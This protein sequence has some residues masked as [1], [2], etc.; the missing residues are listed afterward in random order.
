VL[1]NILLAA[2]TATVLL[3]TLFPLIREAATGEAI[4]VG[5]P[6]FNL[7]FTPLMAALLILLPAGPLLSWKRGDAKGVLQRLWLAAALALV[8][9]GGA[10]LLVSPRHFWGSMGV[11]LSAWL[12]VGA[13]VEIAER[14]GRGSVAETWRRLVALP[15]GA[16]GM[17]LAH[18]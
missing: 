4:S 18:M 1:N 9:A 14:T 5:P 3:G 8:V 2:A 7:T 16:L 15:R 12:I 6:Y 10:L 13:L 11:G 17:T